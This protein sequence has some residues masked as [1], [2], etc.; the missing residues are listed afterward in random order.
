M[1][2]QND[3]D[4]R[5]LNRHT[6]APYTP[7]HPVPTIGG[8]GAIQEER[9][10]A[11]NEA[12]GQHNAGESSLHSI[13]ESVKTHVGLDTSS[14]ENSSIEEQPYKSENHNNELCDYEQGGVHKDDQVN[15][16]VDGKRGKAEEHN[17]DESA[18]TTANEQDARQKR[19]NMKHMKRDTTGREVTDP[20]THLPVMIHDSTSKELYKV[21]ENSPP[22]DSSTRRRSTRPKDAS[23]SKTQLNKEQAQTQSEHRGMKKLFPPP[24]FEATQLELTEVYTRAVTFG[25]VS[26]GSTTILMLAAAHTLI[27]SKEGT[28]LT[29]LL[30]Y[31]GI[32]VVVGILIGTGLI[33]GVRAWLGKRVGDVWEDQV[34]EAAKEEE[35]DDGSPTPES[36]K[37]LNSL[38]SSVWPLINPDLFTSLAD[39]LEDVMQASLPKLV[40]MISV[41]DLGQGSEAIRIL[42]IRWLPSGAAAE[43]ISVDGKKISG[44]RNGRSDWKAPEEGEL[45]DD[46]R[47][48]GRSD[49]NHSTLSDEIEDGGGG[50]N[51]AEGM[52]AE[53]GDFINMEV[54]FSYRASSSSKSLRI[55]S[56]NAHLFLA[57]YLPGGIRFRK[58]PFFTIDGTTLWHGITFGS[59]LGGTP[60]YDRDHED[61][62]TTVSRPSILRPLY[63]DPPGTTQS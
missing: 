50:E 2:G 4:E 35:E 27:K 34:W 36:T 16:Q 9:H 3:F 53:E 47:S 21:P 7:Q 17:D 26:T 31:L 11:N 6:N 22:P 10:A 24:H 58:Y 45:E 1:S 44:K 63:V 38:L 13:I 15:L 12:N 55:K 41:E 14:K 60:R 39:T 56:K 33:L 59:C 43:T 49:G 51:V 25:L 18:E 48:N 32:V 46:S 54:A 19:K 42:G 37:W 61:A 30:V 20:V 57:F 8:Y 52:E 5:T 40:R 29:Y 62:P 28:S 23:K